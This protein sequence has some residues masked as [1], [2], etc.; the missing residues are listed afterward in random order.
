MSLP[1]PQPK[2]HPLLGNLPEMSV[3]AGALFNFMRLAKLY[4]PILK[5]DIIGR[6]VI[7]VSSHELIHELCDESRFDKQISRPLQNV[8]SFAGDGLFTAYTHEPNWLRAHRILMPA[9]GPLAIRELFEPMRDVAEQMMLRWE[10]FGPDAVID[11]ADNMTR[12]TLD[13]IALCAFD[14]RFNSFYQNEMHPFVDAMVSALEESGNRLRRL[15][16]QNQLM[17]LTQKRY[18]DN[19]HYLHKI[20]DE[21][22]AERKRDPRG[23]DKQDLLNRMLQ[24]RDP[25]S[26]EGLSDENIR[27]QLVTFLIA[28]HETTS[29]LLSFALHLL[30]KHPHIL[31]QARAEVDAVLGTSAAGTDDLPK[32]GLID[33]ILKESLRLWPTAPAFAVHP[34]H[35]TLLAGKY[36]VKPDDIILVL[37]PMLHR[38]PAIWGDDVEKFDPDRFLPEAYARLPEDAWKPFGNG[39]R[40]CIGRP[41]AMQ[42]AQLVLAMILQRFDL[43]PHDPAYQ[44]KIKETLTIKPEGLQIRV[45]RRGAGPIGPRRPVGPPQ[46]LKPPE[47]RLQPVGETTGLLVLYGSNTGSAKAFAQRIAGDAPARGFSPTLAAMDEYA[48]QLPQQGAVAIVTASYEGQPPDNARQF[49]AWAESLP[50]GAL[51]GVH[52]TVFG[53][54]NRDWVHTYQAVPKRVDK[55]LDTAGATR[56]RARGEADARGDFFGDFDRWYEGFWDELAAAFGQHAAAGASPRLSVERVSETRAERLRES[57]L[58]AATVLV[59]RELVDLSRPAARSKR[60][61]E[62]QLP[63]GMSYRAGDYLAVLP[64]NPADTVARALRRFGFERESRIVIQA[65]GASALPTGHPVGVAEVLASYVELGQPATRRQVEQLAA[66]T[67]CPPEKRALEALAQEPAYADEVL[68]RRVSVLELLERFGACE[69]DFADFLAMLPSMRPRQYSISSSPLWQ[70]DRC[71]LTVAVVDAPALSGQGRFLGAASTYL[72]QLQPGDKLS[73]AVRA[74]NSAFHPPDRLDTPLML[75]C[76]GTGLAPFRGFLQERALRAASGETPGPALLFYGCDDPEGDYLYRD[77]LEAWEQAGIV[78]LR[79][80]FSAVGD[81][82][83]F[84]QH[85]V[86]QD[87]A[88]VIALFRQG[89]RVFVCGDAQRLLPG[90]RQTIVEM[91]REA[92]G[93]DADAAS[94]W[95]TG[96]ER[97]HARYYADVFA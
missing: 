79:P 38:D 80:A 51:K 57:E 46:T 53:C 26:G 67:A 66:A 78:Q 61:L 55:A 91:Y 77:E 1:I 15:P 60:H 93:A 28:G 73:V 59:N 63:E 12:L 52:Y 42:E 3:E 16:L 56:L 5:L 64:I 74:S 2:P 31:H 40:A 62:L 22:I 44:L 96:L 86:W 17:L 21:L 68:A 34:H 7:L 23:A 24:G 97:D 65:P 41:F 89:A 37:L 90:L 30:L 39:Q 8:R 49:V 19:I 82:V 11:V 10:R 45:Q 14:Y 72:A 92:T 85:R 13:T 35:E 70:P 50:A 25:V 20:A 27:Y 33:R 75:V 48:H 81:P 95:L 87:R 4:G 43:I 29:G 71:T 58:R 47:P 83:R 94:A 88:E 18:E 84:V 36:A 32:L 6:E 69:L 9:F 76:A 54:G